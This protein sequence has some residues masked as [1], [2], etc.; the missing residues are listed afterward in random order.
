MTLK[1]TMQGTQ[2]GL[3]T[4][5]ARAAG[6][7]AAS[8]VI[9][10]TLTERS[11]VT[12]GETAA[13]VR[14][15]AA[16]LLDTGV[17]PGDRVATLQWNNQEHLEVHYGVPV[18]GAVIHTLNPRLTAAELAYIIDDAGDRVV[19]VDA[20]LLGVLAPVLELTK[21]VRTVIVTRGSGSAGP[22]AGTSAGALP[23]WP[24][25][26]SA[27][28]DVLTRAPALAEFP[29][30]AED[31]ASVLCYTSGTTGPPKG[32]LYSH[33]SLFL[34]ALMTCTTN[35]LGVGE[36]DR[37]LAIAPLFHANGWGFAYAS[38]LSGADLI[39]PDRV[40]E[41]RRLVSLIVEERPTVSSGVPT[42]W[43]RIM[44]I[45]K[46]TGADLSSLRLVQCGGSAVPSA[47][48]EYY[49]NEHG[50][51][52]QQAW[53]MTET[54]PIAAVS[55]PPKQADASAYWYYRR[56]AGRILPGLEARI[57]DDNGDVL[58]SDGEA[59]GELEV[60]GPWV[61]GSY[62]G[63]A[64]T[65][66]SFHDGWLRT[67]DVGTL[68]SQG[69]IRITDRSKDV[70]KSGGEWISSIDIENIACGHEKAAMCCVIGVPHPKWDE[71]PLL[72]VKLKV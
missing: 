1:S 42:V 18:I 64:A 47:L 59:I 23:G 46:E 3:S 21:T 30:I 49:Q 54:G 16:G 55:K 34:H 24:G 15:L 2:L 25:E 31:Q 45:A 38:L 39:L 11:V 36:T 17:L 52:I 72:L 10:R 65:D 61:T 26:I 40:M 20:E 57:C 43:T 12:F 6:P 27:Y 14:Q 62:F 19:I 68:D 4:I 37:L 32:V 71:R 58:P 50:V 44:E 67:G 63:A 13:R 70:I 28:G 69:Y 22:G 29:E 53:G 5:L 41:P 7:Y 35:A 66:R 48:M 8:S 9:T 56:A 51:F 33:R 60:R